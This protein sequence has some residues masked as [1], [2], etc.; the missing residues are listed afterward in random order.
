LITIVQL[1]TLNFG[2]KMV[3]KKVKDNE[4]IISGPTKIP[5][6]DVPDYMEGVTF[7]KKNEKNRLSKTRSKE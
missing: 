5:D 3:E 2:N 4:K 6:L 7:E 1:D